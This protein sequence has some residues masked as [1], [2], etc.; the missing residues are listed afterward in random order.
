MK[1]R[2]MNSSFALY[3]NHLEEYFRD[4]TV[5]IVDVSRGGKED[6]ERK[7]KTQ[8]WWLILEK[9]IILQ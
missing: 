6:E 8:S 3:M 7:N 2:K 9:K 1:H 4:S 5:L